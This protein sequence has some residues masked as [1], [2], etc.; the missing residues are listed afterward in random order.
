MATPK[1]GKTF[2]E[3]KRHNNS[4]KMRLKKRE[5]RLEVRVSDVQYLDH[6]LQIK[7]TNETENWLLRSPRFLYFS[8]LHGL[9]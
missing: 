3:S 1:H 9:P 2:P 5:K 6:L 4:L 8:E 7:S